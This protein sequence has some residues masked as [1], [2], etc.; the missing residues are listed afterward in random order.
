M[1]KDIYLN[2]TK[3]PSDFSGG[4][5][6]ERA[7]ISRDETRMAY[8]TKSGDVSIEN[9]PENGVLQTDSGDIR[10]QRGSF[11]SMT[12][13]GDGGLHPVG[14]LNIPSMNVSNKGVTFTFG[15]LES[16]VTISGST[17]GALFEF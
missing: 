4:G 17:T 9:I 15:D 3:L 12:I 6:M 5:I 16:I 7:I 11:T 8:V 13:G 14:G 10:Y 1:T 2:E